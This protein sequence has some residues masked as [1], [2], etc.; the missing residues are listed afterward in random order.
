MNDIKEDYNK[1][2]IQFVKIKKIK[3]LE[4][5]ESKVEHHINQEE[6]YILSKRNLKKLREL[7]NEKENL[8]KKFKK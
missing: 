7:K 5:N 8:E 2:K 6:K 1:N 4:R 3:I